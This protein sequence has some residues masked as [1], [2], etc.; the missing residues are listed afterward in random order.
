ML[1]GIAP[2]ET[3]IRRDVHAKWG[4]RQQGGIGPSSQAP[5]VLFFTDPATGRKHGYYDGWD[6]DG[7][8]NYVGEGQKGDQRLVQG[9]KAILNHTADGRTLEG[10]LAKGTQ[11]TYLGEFTL[12]DYYFTDAPES[13]S[14]D[15]RQV[16]VFRLR[17]VTDVPV[18][19]PTIPFTTS[20][21][22]AV[23]VVPVEEINTETAF[24][25]PDREPYEMERR[26]SLLVRRYREHLTAA[27]HTV[28][29]LRIVPVGESAPLFCDLWDEQDL[30]LIEAK[31]T[32]TRE[33]VRMAVA[34]LHDYGRF[35]EHSRKTLLV[36][37]PLRRDLALF[38]AAM[39]V[40]VVFPDG[41]GWTR[42][43]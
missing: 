17:P 7:Y 23:A 12:V 25:T 5:V 13:G 24:V 34:Q 9:N 11:V 16:V 29:R 38:A 19:L 6:E 10:F 43:E 22:P 2:G 42:I 8:F 1:D 3:W 21:T 14:E 30:E 15:L 18:S 20:D 26:E 27:G 39:G 40:S 36:P 4:G 31:G 28:A 37:G 32:V 41:D 35:V 33:S